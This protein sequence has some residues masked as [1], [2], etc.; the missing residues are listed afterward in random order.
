M[1]LPPCHNPTPGG[2]WRSARHSRL[3][4]ALLL[5]GAVAPGLHAQDV[6]DLAALSLEDLLDLEIV[7]ASRFGQRI[8]QAPSAVQVITADD[9]RAH[10][11]RTLGEALDSLPGLYVSETG[12]YAYL[13]ARGELG[14]GD[15]NTRFLLLVNGHRINDA[16]YSQSPVGAEFPLDMSLVERIE[17]APGPGSA[18][19][20]S[21]AFF[22]VINVL[23]RDAADFGDG[24]LRAGIASFGTRDMQL[25]LPLATGAGSTLLSVRQMHSR[26][27]DL[28]FPE[29]ADTPSGGDVRGLDDERVRQVFIDHRQG[30]LALQLVAGD[31]RR[32]D[33]VAPYEQTFA[34]PGAEIQDRWVDF[35]ARYDRTLGAS[36]DA[37]ARLD[38]VDF[39]Y[40]GDYVYGDPDEPYINRDI[41]SGTSVVLGGQV[42]SRAIEGHTLVAGA[43]V[44]FDRSVVQRNFDPDPYASYLDS[45]EDM[46]SFGVFVDDEIRLSDTWRFNGGLRVDRSDLGTVRAS[47]R[48][49]LIAARAQTVFKLI[50]GQSYRSPNAYERYYQVESEDSSQLAN[51]ALGAEHVQ[52]SELYYS[53]DLSPRHRAEASVYHYRL[54]DLVT[55][56]EIDD[57]TLMLTN[58]GTGSSRG[59]ELAY[60]HRQDGGLLLRAS[61]AYSE[62]TDSQSPRPVNAPRGIARVSAR[63]P[64]A[65]SLDLAMSARHVGRRASKAGSV[66]AYTVVD[67]HLD[68]APAGSPVSLAL[69]V[70]NLLDERYADPVGPE[71]AQDSVQRRGREYRLEATWRF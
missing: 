70:R 19:Y 30:G 50:V 56:V 48:M 55:L 5:L 1:N 27:R 54:R 60:T 25:S 65:P 24:E 10:G 20:G 2:A 49:A 42:V 57:G 4:A 62:V 21:N 58:A 36:M 41:A 47:P 14:A 34:T 15:Y 63:L 43:E 17:Y 53:V 3:A 12:L 67:T 29:F 38:V 64:L 28:Y 71:F 59:A 69:G 22:G 18:V 46:T 66:A 11:W 61:Y 51:P 13:G 52:T 32:E 33:P 44:Q 39:R 9:I 6:A 37:S 40:L 16:V 35:G 68:W 23:T 8:S 7:T 31:R 45:R 26:G